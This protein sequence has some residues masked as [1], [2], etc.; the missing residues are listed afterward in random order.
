MLGCYQS[1][2][3]ASSKSAICKDCAFKRNCHLKAK[4]TL[5]A[6]DGNFKGFPSDNFVPQK[7][8]FINEN[9]TN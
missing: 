6:L 1:I 8:N 5:L 7:R 3:T 2:L 9:I 4:E